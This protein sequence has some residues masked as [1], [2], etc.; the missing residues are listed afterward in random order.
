MMSCCRVYALCTTHPA[1]GRPTCDKHVQRAAPRGGKSSSF[2]ADCALSCSALVQLT[3][4][5]SI[6]LQLSY[7]SAMGW[8]LFSFGIALATCIHAY[9]NPES[10]FFPKTATE[11][12]F[13]L[14]DFWHR[15][16]FMHQAS[17]YELSEKSHIVQHPPPLDALT[18]AQ[19]KAMEN[20]EN[21]GSDDD[22]DTQITTS[23][24]S[25]MPAYFISH[26]TPNVLFEP[27]TMP[28][29][30][31]QALGAE[32]MQHKPKAIVVVSSGWVGGEIVAEVNSAEE[33]SLICEHTC[34][35]RLY[36]LPI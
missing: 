26:G 16:W 4:L 12:Q 9:L 33:N 34:H 8:R 28:Y 27:E 13:R 6:K 20:Q 17:P 29:R 22:D 30:S 23:P 15:T 21:D 24:I 18:P 32:I 25:K 36:M 35:R 7:S 1:I 5:C 2:F 11:A 3:A 14:R 31:L 10:N 19:R